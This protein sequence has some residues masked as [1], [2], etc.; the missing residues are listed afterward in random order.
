MAVTQLKLADDTQDVAS[1]H[2][3]FTKMSETMN[4]VEVLLEGTEAIRDAGEDYLPRY[5]AEL[6]ANYK[7]RLEKSTLLPAFSDTIDYLV[8][9]VFQRPITLNPE[10]TPARIADMTDNIDPQKNDLN[11]F[12]N[13]LFRDMLAN[14]LSHILV[15]MTPIPRNPDGTLPIVTQ[16]DTKNR[17]P[18]WVHIK[19]SQV[20]AW[21][22][23]V[24]NG[25]QV[26]T[27]IRI[28]EV[29]EI[30]EGDFGVKEVGQIRVLEIGKFR[31]F[32]EDDKGNWVEKPELGGEML[33]RNGKPFPYIP[34]ITIYAM[35]PSAFMTA[36]PPLLDLAYKNVEHYQVHSDYRN[37]LT[38][39]CFP[40]L[41]V[42][43]YKSDEDGK[44]TVGPTTL[45]QFS[46]E[47]A[48]AYYVEHSGK[49]LGSA[50]THL[51]D[52]KQEMAASGLQLLMP[53]TGA[54]PTATG[55][56]IDAAK[57][58]SELQ[59]MAHRLKDGLERALDATADWMG[60]KHG[61]EVLINT[62]LTLTL[63]KM[64]IDQ[65][66][67]A[68][69]AGLIP[70]EVGWAEMIR[71]GFLKDQDLKELKAMLEDEKMANTDF[72]TLAGSLL[73][74]PTA[75]TIPAGSRGTSPNLPGKGEPGTGQP[76][77][78]A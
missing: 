34:L 25:S 7:K 46:S 41:A 9:K 30:P 8:G 53:K 35:Q 77:I 54:T 28:R 68:M 64:D 6:S 44:I 36:P 71:R 52:L 10:T 19:A 23:D 59:S 73:K 33:D 13:W 18:Y 38:M 31:I 74:P 75:A 16:A 61:S 5:E 55:E 21:R 20:F 37:C 49:A 57:S 72:A 12:A 22:S 48:K 47:N 63:G 70:K 58:T 1:E 60:E 56:A 62:D 42:S 24:V 27:Q 39:A 2:P 69:V 43:G 67:K 15:D 32:Q 66:I 76:P 78:G 14:G 40:I 29:V 50:R 26:A 3:N 51:E 11:V 65:L 45:M 17:L 4:M